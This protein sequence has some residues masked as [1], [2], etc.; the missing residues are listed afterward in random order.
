M[1]R[2]GRPRKVGERYPNGRI[3]TQ[4]N[5]ERMA[6]AERARSDVERATVLSQPHRRGEASQLAESAI[7]RFVLKN[8]IR[9]E[10]YEAAEIYASVKMKWLSAMGARIQ[11]SGDPGTGAD[12]PMELVHAWRDQTFGAESMMVRYASP[13]GCLSVTRMA[14]HRDEF[15]PG[16]SRRSAIR[17]LM[18]LA[19]FFGKVDARC[20]TD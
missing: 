15:A 3:K 11:Y 2:A 17:A 10:C 5:L 1:A 13:D 7:G 4:S 6:E 19:V 12:I 20:L 16:A 18:A 9:H 8:R 14:V